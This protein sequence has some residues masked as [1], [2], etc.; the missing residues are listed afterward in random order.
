M[1]AIYSLAAMPKISCSY[2]ITLPYLKFVTRSDGHFVPIRHYILDPQLPTLLMSNGNRS[3]ISQFDVEKLACQYHA[4]IVRYDYS[5]R[6]MHTSKNM[7]EEQCQ[8]DIIAVFNYLVNCQI[9]NIYIVGFSL[10]TYFSSYLASKVCHYDCVKGLILISSFP[11]ITKTMT[12]LSLPGDFCKTED[13]ACQ[14][15]CPT[16]IVHGFSDYLCGLKQTI[17]MSKLFPN[18]YDFV[19]VNCAH[20]KMMENQD[21]IN[22]INNFIHRC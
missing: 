11:S 19:I 8:K 10:G 4:N 14:V 22:A 12:N 7:T 6:G 20:H 16:L 3:C 17:M 18:L 21:C 15:F 9:N 5:G 1:G 13:L 2:D